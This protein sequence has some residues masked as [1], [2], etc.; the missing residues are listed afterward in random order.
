M[1]ALYPVTENATREVK[2]INNLVEDWEDNEYVYDYL[3]IIQTKITLTFRFTN[4]QLKINQ[5]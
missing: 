3:T 4:L 2:Y 5:K 1:S